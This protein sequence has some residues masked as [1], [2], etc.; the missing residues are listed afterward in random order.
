MNKFV[1][2][3]CNKYMTDTNNKF[4]VLMYLIK[5]KKFY[6]RYHWLYSATAYNHAYMDTG[7][8]CI[9]ASCTPSHVK[10]RVE[11]IVHEMVA[12]ASGISD[13]ELSV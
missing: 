3:I 10:D 8:F 6:C 2:H 11:V 9:H 1:V 4:L 5:K 7:L 12:M 13:N